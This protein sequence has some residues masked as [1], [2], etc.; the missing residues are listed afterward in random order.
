MF[1]YQC[2]KCKHEFDEYVQLDKRNESQKCPKCGGNSPR[3]FCA[4]AMVVIKNQYS[5]KT[6]RSTTTYF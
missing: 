4:P 6:G 2:E 3:A 1:S 5:T